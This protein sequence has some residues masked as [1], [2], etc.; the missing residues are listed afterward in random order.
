MKQRRMISILLA[1]MLLAPV[2]VSAQSSSPTYRVEESQFGSGGE[3]D[4]T[5]PTYRAQS[6]AGSLGVGETSSANYDGIAGFLTPNE[7]FLEM[8]VTAATVNFGTLSDTTTS[9]GAAQ[10]GA[11]N[12]SFT[13]RTYLSSAYSVVTSGQMTNESGAIIDA[14]T[15][16]GA[17]STDQNVEE[18]GINLVDNSN[19]NIGVNALNIPDNNFADGTAASG[20]STVDQFKY[21]VGDTIARSPATAG[22]QAVGQTNYTISYIAKSKPI[23]E[24]GV[25]NLNH[26]LI[27]VPTY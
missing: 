5:S 26:V 2:M 18:F 13:V 9:S 23:T 8:I 16:L 20:Y 17:P 7:P 21:A 27:V 3:V 25:Y 1:L 11:C 19:P 15:I 10:A 22:N 24:A 4:T 6:S 14:K 12:C